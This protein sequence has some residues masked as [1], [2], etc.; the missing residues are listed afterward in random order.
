MRNYFEFRFLSMSLTA[1]NT[2]SVERNHLCNFVKDTMGNNP[3]NLNHWYRRKCRLNIK[4]TD[5]Q[6]TTSELR[7][8]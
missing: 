1:L 7:D 5:Q 2:C 6:I 4:L 8:M 3:V